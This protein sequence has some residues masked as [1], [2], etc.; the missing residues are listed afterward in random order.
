M[1]GSHR[2]LVRPHLRRFRSLVLWRAPSESNSSEARGDFAGKAPAQRRSCQKGNLF[3]A[4]PV[5]SS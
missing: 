4:S 3:A 1:K 2:R 5:D